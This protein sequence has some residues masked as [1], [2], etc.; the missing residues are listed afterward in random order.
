MVFVPEDRVNLGLVLNASITDNAILV[1][2]P[3]RASFLRRVD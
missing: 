2:L 1:R 3:G